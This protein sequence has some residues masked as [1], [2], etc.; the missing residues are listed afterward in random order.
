[1]KWPRYEKSQDSRIKV[2]PDILDSMR[3]L[4]NLGF[5]QS[6]I[7]EKLGICQAT[8][9]YHLNPERRKK[10][11]EKCKKIAEEWRKTHREEFSKRKRKYQKKKRLLQGEKL[12][13]YNKLHQ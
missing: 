7:G 12:K 11:I 3:S 2:T 9:N 13:A 4:S 6:K 8:V 10:Q 1:M 5:S